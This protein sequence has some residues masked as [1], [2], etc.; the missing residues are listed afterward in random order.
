M[1]AAPFDFVDICR[2]IVCYTWRGALPPSLFT[3]GLQRLT[4]GF[5]RGFFMIGR[6]MVAL[7]PILL[8]LLHLEVL[9]NHH[10]CCNHRGGL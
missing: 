2:P 10:A 3:V 5:E 1:K 4:R 7:R 9:H 6:N 8:G